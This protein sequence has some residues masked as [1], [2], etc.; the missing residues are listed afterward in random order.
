MFRGSLALLLC[1]LPALCVTFNKDVAPVVFEHCAPCH[2]D[3]G[4]GPFPLMNY[5]DVSKH[6][7]QITAVT[8][9][10]YMPPWPPVHGFGEFAGDRSL[11]PEQIRL[12]AEW[13]KQ[14][15]PEGDASDLPLPPRFDSKWQLGPPD[16]ILKMDKPFTLPAEGSDIFPQFHFAQRRLRNALCA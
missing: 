10:R 11:S 1:S 2:H 9:S 13:L 5:A 15:K 4:I 14:G 3:G 6:A 7:A 16:L 12:F 8:Q